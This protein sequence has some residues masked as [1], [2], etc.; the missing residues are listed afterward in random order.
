MLM[1]YTRGGDKVLC[2]L[3]TFNNYRGRFDKSPDEINIAGSWVGFSVPSP[4]AAEPSI[5][6]YS[7][8]R[9]WRTRDLQAAFKLIIDRARVPDFFTIEC[10]T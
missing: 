5:L 9:S 10:Y 7:R 1:G 4:R 2:V 8:A 3:T 6:I